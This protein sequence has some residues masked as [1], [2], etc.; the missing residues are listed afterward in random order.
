MMIAKSGVNGDKD[1]PQEETRRYVEIRKPRLTPIWYIFVLIVGSCTL[2]NDFFMGLLFVCLI[3]LGY[4]YL[5]DVLN[6]GFTYK[7]KRYV[8]EESLKDDEGEIE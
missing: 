7:E 4:I 8:K 3:L 5:D 2:F 6:H 1:K